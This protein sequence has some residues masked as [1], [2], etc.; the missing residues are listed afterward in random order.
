MPEAAAT[1]GP[2]TLR[3]TP[4]PLTV[5]G[6]GHRAP[7]SGLADAVVTAIPGRVP[8]A[9]VKG[10]RRREHCGVCGA[11]LSLPARASTK[12]V[13]FEFAGGVVT[14]TVEGPLVRCPECDRDQLTHGVAGR[15]GAAVAAA[16]EFAVAPPDATA[17]GSV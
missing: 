8:A 3:L 7:L 4:I 12:P 16:I 6:R 11:V 17:T 5:C 2:V 15:L 9:V 14:A 13:P 1:L 10:V